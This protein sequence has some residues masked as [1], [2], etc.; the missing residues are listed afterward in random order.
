MRRVDCS[1]AL[2]RIRL[3]GM[4]IPAPTSKRAGKP[5]LGAGLEENTALLGTI[6]RWRCERASHRSETPLLDIGFDEDKASLT[7]VDMDDAGSVR[8]DRGEEVLRLQAVYYI[9]QLLSVS[10]EE[11]RATSRA[12]ADANNIA[13]NNL[14]AVGSSIERLVVATG[15]VG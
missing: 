13:L 1:Q 10:G 15:S 9:L 12:V 14:R 2:S 8:A 7:K 11:N 5:I 4:T 6:W 3:H